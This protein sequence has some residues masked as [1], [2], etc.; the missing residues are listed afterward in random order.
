MVEKIKDVQVQPH[1]KRNHYDE[2]DKGTHLSQIFAFSKFKKHVPKWCHIR[3]WMVLLH[4]RDLW[5][6]ETRF[7]EYPKSS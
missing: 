1:C 6:K 3:R 2:R 7:I 5:A 4:L